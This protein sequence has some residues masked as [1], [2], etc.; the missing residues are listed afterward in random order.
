MKLLQ[1]VY[2]VAT[3]L[4]VDKLRRVGYSASHVAVRDVANFCVGKTD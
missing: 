3:A 1:A 2:V 4:P